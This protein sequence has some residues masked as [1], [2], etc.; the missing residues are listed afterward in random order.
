MSDVYDRIDSALAEWIRR[1]HV[2]FVATAPRAD[3]GYV[4]CSP[5]GLDSLRVLDERTIAYLDLTGSGVET[6]AHLKENGR[7]VVMLCAFDGPPRI[8]RLH[9]RG[10]VIAPNDPAFAALAATF[11]PQSGVRSVIRV[12]LT[13]ISDSC[14]YA[15]PLMNFVA[16]REALTMWSD[17]KGPDGVVEYQREKNAAS[18]DG[19]TG[20]DW[21]GRAAN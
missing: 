9:G 11:P 16:E 18:L 17:K 1:Q 2:Y 10:T 7:I 4:N 5:K 20:V 13:R 3:D 21:L 15:V 14:G 8:V 6:I 12:E 19:L